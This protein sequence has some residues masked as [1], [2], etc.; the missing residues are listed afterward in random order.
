[1]MARQCVLVRGANRSRSAVPFAV[2]D[3]LLLRPQQPPGLAVGDGGPVA[4]RPGPLRPQGPA[5]VLR[6]RCAPS[7]GYAP[8]RGVF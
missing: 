6:G 2:D 4:R 5:L 8:A 3:P 1:M 7:D